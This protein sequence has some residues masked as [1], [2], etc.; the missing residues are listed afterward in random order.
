MD[1]TLVTPGRYHV[2]TRQQMAGAAPSM[3]SDHEQP[4]KEP[5]LPSARVVMQIR[6]P[7][8]HK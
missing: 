3:A 7:Q 5:L 1:V 6:Y 4:A 8:K 2:L